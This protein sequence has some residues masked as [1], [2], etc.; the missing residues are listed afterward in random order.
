MNGYDEKSVAPSL[1]TIKGRKVYRHT[2]SNAGD[3]LAVLRK[4][5]HVL[6]LGGHL[7]ATERIEYE[8]AGVKTRFNQISAV[9]GGPTNAAG[10]FPS[11]VT[12]YRVK[13]G[14]I[15]NGR[16]VPLDPVR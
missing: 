11:G 4:R 9:I 15:D 5:R 6:A 2:V 14:S 3:V 16:F 8:M 10:K 13:N 7:H 1:I 12:L